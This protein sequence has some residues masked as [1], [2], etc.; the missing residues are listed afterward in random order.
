MIYFYY[1][2]IH[3]KRSPSDETLPTYDTVSAVSWRIG[4]AVSIN[5]IAGF[6]SNY[7]HF[8]QCQ[9]T[10]HM[11]YY[12]FVVMFPLHHGVNGIWWGLSGMMTF[13]VV[14]N[15]LVNAVKFMMDN[16]NFF[17]MHSGVRGIITS[18]IALIMAFT[19]SIISI[20][21]LVPMGTLFWSVESRGDPDLLYLYDT[22]AEV[23]FFGYGL[24]GG[25]GLGILVGYTLFAL[26]KTG[27]NLTIIRSF[28][29]GVV[30]VFMSICAAVM[31][32]A[33]FVAEN[34]TAFIVRAFL[35]ASGVFMLWSINFILFALSAWITSSLFYKGACR[36]AI[37]QKWL[38]GVKSEAPEKSFG[39]TH[40]LLN[41]SATLQRPFL[42]AKRT[43][44]NGTG[45]AG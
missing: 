24:V 1:T 7:Y 10:D 9:E 40:R 5:F 37:L 30:I 28:V 33:A 17:G 29:R 27:I 38:L 44:S 39:K 45:R 35:G 6:L 21:V 8:R 3:K 25:V 14:A 32:W 31:A 18:E 19:Y 26:E 11:N 34:S 4:V 23:V 42:A 16:G 15:I 20:S 41:L 36:A 22:N 13:M 2:I 12:D 43:R